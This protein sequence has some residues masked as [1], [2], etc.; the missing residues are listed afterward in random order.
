MTA[1]GKKQCQKEATLCWSCARAVGGCPWTE[2]DEKTHQVRFAPVEGWEAE[3]TI[4]R[5]ASSKRHGKQD[6]GRRRY[7]YSM[8]SY[9][10]KK[11]PLY[12]K[13]RRTA[14]NARYRF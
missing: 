1:R 4:I 5:G 12:Q 3:K 8:E 7:C 9:R 6:E 11:C 13:D 14:A 10:V 2:R